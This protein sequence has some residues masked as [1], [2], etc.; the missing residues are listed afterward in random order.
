MLT[1]MK[2]AR[3]H[4]NETALRPS[5]DQ[6]KGAPPDSDRIVSSRDPIDVSSMKDKNVKS[7]LSVGSSFTPISANTIFHQEWSQL[8][9]C[10]T[11]QR[12]QSANDRAASRFPKRVMAPPRIPIQLKSEPRKAP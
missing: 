10:S 1:A 2:S 3:E 7:N 8:C 12:A 11:I 6:L 5:N 9:Q 4:P